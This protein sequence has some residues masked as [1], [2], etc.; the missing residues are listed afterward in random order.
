M[1]SDDVSGYLAVGASALRAVRLAQA[2]ANVPDFTSILDFPC[3][4]GRVLRWF[5]AAYPRAQLTAGDVLADGVDWC[6]REF[7]AVG[8]HA[9][10]QPDTALFEHRYDLIWVGSL[11]THVDVPQWRRFLDVWHDL[12]ARD[13]LLVITTHGDYVAERMERGHLY[14]YPELQVK[15][16]LRAYRHAGFGFLEESPSSV[17]YGITI[18]RPDWVLRQVMVESDLRLVLAVEM[19]WDNHQDVYA[20]VRREFSP[21]EPG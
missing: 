6:S 4:H 8:V 11:L 9:A 7:G 3:G 1:P 17:E 18:S 14:G 21:P 13:G 20:F 19:L 5:K 15:R 10:P 2:S 16:L 12:L